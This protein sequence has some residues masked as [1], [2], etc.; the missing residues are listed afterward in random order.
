MDER[1]GS[2]SER[3]KR[4]SPKSWESHALSPLSFISGLSMLWAA[5]CGVKTS[6]HIHR[7]L[8]TYPQGLGSFPINRRHVWRCFW[9]VI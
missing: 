2:V 5:P 8:Q 1:Y 3:E 6:F 9:L 4:K 7:R